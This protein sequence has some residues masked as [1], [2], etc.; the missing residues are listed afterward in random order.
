MQKLKILFILFTVCAP[1]FMYAQSKPKRDTSKDRSVVV[2]KQQAQAKKKAAEEAA[3][4]ERKHALEVQRK[5]NA[6]VRQTPKSASYLTV[7]Q[8]TSVSKTLGSNSG[9]ERFNVNTDGKEWSVSY[10]PAWCKVTKYD[11]YFI[12]SYNGN[13]SHD[14]RSDWFEVKCDNQKVRVNVTQNGTP[15]NIKSHFNYAN[16]AHNVEGY[17]GLHQCLKI[18]ANVTIQGAKGQK[19]LI[20]AFFNDEYNNSIKATSRFS[21]FGLLPSYRLYVTAEIT[22]VSDSSESYNITL[23]LPNNAMQLQK[24]KNRLSC[25]LA[26]YCPKTSSY[27]SGANYTMNF[28]AKNKKGKVTT[29]R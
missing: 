2:A 13:T 24:K 26:V 27:I 8:L 10:L 17:M 21:H 12:L 28:T 3:A 14:D 15:L 1:C 7:N 16:L 20:V 25:S 23:Y 6:Q 9:N 4:K 5:R 22:P 19:C 29:K 18:N 11:N